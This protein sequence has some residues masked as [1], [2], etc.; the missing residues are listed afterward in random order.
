MWID[1]LVGKAFRKLQASHI[2]MRNQLYEVIEDF[3][4]HVEHCHEY[5]RSGIADLCY[6]WDEEEGYVLNPIVEVLGTSSEEEV[7][8]EI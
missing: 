2:V 8:Y 1:W 5:D 4:S 3:Y 7:K 6:V